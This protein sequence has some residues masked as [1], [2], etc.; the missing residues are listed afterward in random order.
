MALMKRVLVVL[1][2]LVVAGSGCAPRTGSTQAQVPFP[3]SPAPRGRDVVLVV[4]PNVEHTREVYQALAAELSTEMD[5]VAVEFEAKDSVEKLAQAI[6]KNSPKALVLMDNRVLAAYREYQRTRPPGSKFP[7]SVVVMTSFL[8]EQYR[9]VVNATGI[10][11]EVPSIT[12]FTQLRL[13]VKGPVRRVGV[14]HRQFFAGYLAKQ[15]K[16]AS[17]EDIQIRAASVSDKPTAEEV[18]Q[19]L[20]VLKDEGVDALWVLNDSVLLTP[21]LVRKAWLPE[22]KRNTIPVVVGV[23]KL[24]TLGRPFGTFAVIPDHPALGV[25]AASM[26]FDMADH[27]WVSPPRVAQ[28]LSTRTLANFK[29]AEKMFTLSPQARQRVDEAV[30]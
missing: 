6:T 17:R 19:A 21:E 22:L 30:E 28:P 27:N 16:L 25:Q 7:P 14:I 3:Q 1:F 29:L 15:Q 12:L 2:T 5:V 20:E 26:I 4:M 24:L 23:R 18:E 9:Y 8:S 10:S 11:Y 13:L